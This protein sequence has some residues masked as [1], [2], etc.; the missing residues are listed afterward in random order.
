MLLDLLWVIVPPILAIV[1][2]FGAARLGRH[3]RRVLL[4]LLVAFGAWAAVMALYVVLLASAH[5]RGTLEVRN[6]SSEAVDISGG[7]GGPHLL[8]PGTTAERSG[9]PGVSILSIKLTDG[10][11]IEF[12]FSPSVKDG[13]TTL[14]ENATGE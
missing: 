8:V 10:R 7:Q 12:R 1:L 2:L 5:T 11:E 9:I 3:Q 4:G 6:D 14:I 13:S